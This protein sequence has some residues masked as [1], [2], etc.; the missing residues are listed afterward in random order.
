MSI[1][2]LQSEKNNL[3]VK[4]ILMDLIGL[5]KQRN[6]TNL[7]MKCIQLVTQSLYTILRKKYKVKK[8]MLAD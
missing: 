1:K 8:I 2:Q 6:E 3:E 7:Y 4:S 5:S